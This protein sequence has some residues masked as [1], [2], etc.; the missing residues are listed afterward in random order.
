MSELQELK[1]QKKQIEQR[2]RELECTS[3]YCNRA[4]LRFDRYSG[5]RH[6]EWKVRY[7][8]DTSYLVDYAKDRSYFIA[9]ANTKEQ[10]LENLKTA[11]EDLQGLLE[12]VLGGYTG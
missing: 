2:I 3:I 9:I 7:R 1:E 4:E 6:A 12:K 10:C 8:V 5:G 11:I